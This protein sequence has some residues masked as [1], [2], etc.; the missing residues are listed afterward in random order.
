MLTRLPV[1]RLDALETRRAVP[2][3]LDFLKTPTLS[4]G[5]Y[6]NPVQQDI[7]PRF[8]SGFA[9]SSII[10][11][12]YNVQKVVSGGGWLRSGRADAGLNIGVHIGDSCTI[13]DK[14]VSILHDSRTW[15]GRWF[16]TLKMS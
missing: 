8:F 15:H 13:R 12:T 5:L 14:C 9:V 10:S 7:D 16:R 4:C 2:V 6:T 11:F 1:Q 3:T